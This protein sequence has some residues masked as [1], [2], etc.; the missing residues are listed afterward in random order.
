MEREWRIS[1]MRALRSETKE[2]GEATDGRGRRVRLEIGQ[3]ERGRDGKKAVAVSSLARRSA[4]IPRN[5]VK[6]RGKRINA[7]SERGTKDGR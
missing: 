6:S 3:R 1:R 7:P 2:G 5:T 4:S